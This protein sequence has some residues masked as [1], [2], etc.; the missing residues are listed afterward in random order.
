[1]ASILDNAKGC[2]WCGAKPDMEIVKH[3]NCGEPYFVV[4]LKCGCG[5]RMGAVASEAEGERASE[6]NQARYRRGQPLFPYAE[7]VGAVVL[8]GRLLER[9][10][11]RVS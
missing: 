3:H 8:E 2:P 11:T 6:I 4:A 10:N 1:M 5:V 9:W 7:L